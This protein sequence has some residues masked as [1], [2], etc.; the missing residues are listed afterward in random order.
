[1]A[2]NE[3]ERWLWTSNGEEIQWEEMNV[4]PIDG[5]GRL[6]VNADWLKAVRIGDYLLLVMAF[7]LLVVVVAARCVEVSNWCA[8][9]RRHLRQIWMLEWSHD[10]AKGDL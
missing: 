7:V 2:N 6:D 8:S 9:I 3:E 1:M 5:G 10:R 4:A